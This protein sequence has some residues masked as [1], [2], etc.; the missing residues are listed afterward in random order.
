[1]IARVPMNVRRS[2]LTLIEVLVVIGVIALLL[3]MLVPA[4]QKVR[5]S[6][7]RTQCT[8]NLKQIG[9][10]LHNFH[11]SNKYLPPGTLV[12]D[13]IV[14]ALHSGFT[15]ILPY[16]EQGLTHALYD[17][18]FAWYEPANFAAVAR[19]VPIFFCPSNRR[20]GSIDLAR[21]IEQWSSPMPPTVAA[22]DYI[23][24]KGANA[25]IYYDP[26][27]VPL[28]VRGLF[29]M[30]QPRTTKGGT[31]WERT[32]VFRIRL[33]DVAGGA[34]STFAVGEGAGGNRHFLLADAEDPSRAAIEPFSN[35]VVMMDQAWSVG[36]ITDR[37]H[38]WYASIYGVT[39][40]FGF[41]YGPRDE[42]M[43]RRP[44]TPSIS[45]S[46]FSGYNVSGKDSISGFRSMHPNGCSF[47]YA[48]GT[49]HWVWQGINPVTYRALSTYA[50][51]ETIP[52]NW[53]N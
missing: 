11:D 40:Q 8:N 7:S 18:G 47:L 20:R 22:T 49:V 24:C 45:S 37:Y 13:S 35:N 27:L 19:E 16:L 42:P 9:L 52:G 39:A 36:C 33:K 53:A 44:G 30:S 23:L 17:F 46:D 32:P 38:P 14:N 34:S 6:A 2:G 41:S 10:A 26:T 31:A 28:Q 51:E 4:V 48:D 21:E 50:G 3:A 15:Y 1:M 43:N 5:E 29:G 12:H 25:G